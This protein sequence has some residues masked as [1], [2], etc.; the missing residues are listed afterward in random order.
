M[1]AAPN[2]HY[3]DRL[4]RRNSFAALWP[5]FAKATRPAKEL[6]ESY[7]ALEHLRPFLPP[8][9]PCRVLHVGDGAH[10]RTA[11][12]FAL[13]TRADNI[14]ID[15]C[16][17]LP[18]LEGWTREHGIVRLSWRKA[19]IEDVA[20][21]L[22]A[23]PPMPVLVTCV[24]AHLPVDDV[25]GQL[26]WDVAFTLA[27]CVPG[28]QLSRRYAPFAEGSDPSVLSEGR[29]FQVLVNPAPDSAG[30]RRMELAHAFGSG[31]ATPSGCRS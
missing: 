24:H 28:H 20:T 22:N 5:L 29:R 11:A 26:R 14:S 19:A 21:E 9:G 15:P 8:D 25:L 10:A 16:L 1:A 27:C 2:S 4:M 31:A 13:K 17:N 7:S 6:T 12:L 23:L 18:L 30:A 3:L